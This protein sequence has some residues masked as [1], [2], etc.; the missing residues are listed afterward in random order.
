MS[1][2]RGIAVDPT[3][4]K[5]FVADT[6]NNRVL[7]FASA[8]AL[9]NGAAAEIVLGQPD[10]VSKGFGTT[11]TTMS[12][13]CGAAVDGY[14]RCGWRISETSVCSVSTTP[15][16]KPPARP[17]TAC[18][19]RWISSR[20]T[21]PSHPRNRASR[22]RS[23]SRQQVWHDLDRRSNVNRVL[24]FD[25]RLG[26]AERRECRR[27]S[28]PARFCFLQHA[29]HTNRGQHGQ[30]GWNHG[31]CRRQ[32]LGRGLRQQP[33]AAV[34]HA[35]IKPLTGASADGVLG[36]PVFN[37]NVSGLTQ[38][39]FTSP[40]G[41]GIDSNG[42]LWVSHFYSHRVLGFRNALTKPNGALADVVL[43][44][45]AFDIAIS[46]V[47]PTASSL[48][49]PQ[50]SRPTAPETSGSPAAIACCDSICGR[51][52]HAA[53]DNALAPPRSR[54]PAKPP[55]DEP[56][57]DP[58]ER[59]RHGAAVS[60]ASNIAARRVVIPQPLARHRGAHR[61]LHPGRNVFFVRA[62]DALGKLG[63][64]KNHRRPQMSA[65]R[66]LTATALLVLAF[67]TPRGGSH[68][69]ASNA[70]KCVGRR[71]LLSASSARPPPA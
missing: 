17:R 61:A 1:S 57:H 16:A 69:V 41:C 71:N 50:K 52:A 38:Y 46:Y 25:L 70:G 54:S 26:E 37:T 65:L 44:Q 3:T 51:H 35:S 58:R 66:I 20:A 29:S 12:S 2:V 63:R 33:R 60:R 55:A 15:R 42:T 11:A 59:Q 48:D 47:P 22:G 56:W 36:Q 45:T 53:S 8:D 43:G 31:R 14:G 40:S 24:R 67:P 49:S 6:N 18:S 39:S 4:G 34:Q 27:R 28:R 13:P 10:F 68:P 30:P 5:I 7:R 19:G 32:S 64:A 23:A 62:V 9:G 21:S